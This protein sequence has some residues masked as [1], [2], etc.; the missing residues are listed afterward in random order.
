MSDKRS[1]ESPVP[2]FILQNSGPI[3][4]VLFSEFIKDI[5]FASNRNGNLNVYDL[6]L[7]RSLFEANSN[8]ESILSIAELNENNIFTHSRNGVIQKW[9][10]S[11]NVWNPL[12]KQNYLNFRFYFIL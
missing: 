10:R 6:N 3:S 11:Q 8:K 9:T 4:C 7:R 12:S 1:N 5:L 2:I